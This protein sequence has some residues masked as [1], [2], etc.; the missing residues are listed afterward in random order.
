MRVVQSFLSLDS[1]KLTYYSYF[2]SILTYRIIFWGNTP[3]SSVIFRM[4][5]RI[6]RIM[7]GIRNR[8]SCREYLTGWKY[9]HYNLIFVVTYEN[10]SNSRVLYGQII[11]PVLYKLGEKC[12]KQQHFIYFYFSEYSTAYC[13]EILA[14]PTVTWECYVQTS[15]AKGYWNLARNIEYMSKYLFSNMSEVHHLMKPF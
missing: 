9:C 5:K 10:H 2:H 12:R 8:D 15:S 13:A 6:V 14:T 4:Q 3:H 7:V 11:Y 1:L